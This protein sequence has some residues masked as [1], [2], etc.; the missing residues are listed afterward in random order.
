[1][2][3]R[4]AKLSEA[5]NSIVYVR[6]VAVADLPQQLQEQIDGL[7]TVYSVHRPD[8]MRVALVADKKL[9]FDLARQNDLAP[10]SVH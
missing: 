2:N 8:G 10:V 3:T 6:A 9:A 4:F 5:T 7:E 1:M